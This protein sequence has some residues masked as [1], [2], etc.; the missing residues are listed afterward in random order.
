MVWNQQGYKDY[1]LVYLFFEYVSDRY[2]GQPFAEFTITR[3]CLQDLI[4]T[5]GKS[6]V[7]ERVD[8]IIQKTLED[9]K[10]Q[11]FFLDVSFNNPDELGS[12]KELVDKVSGLIA[13]F[14]NPAI[15]FRNN[16]ASG[17]DIVTIFGQE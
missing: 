13:V 4:A 6:D 7:G 12:G 15:D 2:K 16:H 14:Q 3:V 9:N 17:D 5:K 10:L 1:V 8:R 11:S